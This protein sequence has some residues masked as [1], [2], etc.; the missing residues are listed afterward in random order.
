[1]AVATK[2]N[3]TTHN[4]SSI[5]A[6]WNYLTDFPSYVNGIR[7]NNIEYHPS[8]AD[9]IIIRDVNSSGPIIFKGTTADTSDVRIKKYEGARK[10]P[11]IHHAECSFAASANVLVIIELWDR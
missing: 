2:F 10:K 5:D 7:V 8:G 3:G 1:M 11:Y 6:N 9:T 4:V